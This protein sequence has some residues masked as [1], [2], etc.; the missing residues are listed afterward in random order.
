MSQGP[1]NW[2]GSAYLGVLIHC[3]IFAFPFLH[4]DRLV[5]S[6]KWKAAINDN[7]NR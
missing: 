5:K 4:E 2:I 1:W 6:K 3:Y 7:I